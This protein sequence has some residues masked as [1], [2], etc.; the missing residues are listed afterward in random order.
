M[1]TF[2]RITANDYKIRVTDKAAS[3]LI[4]RMLVLNPSKRLGMLSGGE[5]DVT[6]HP[7]CAHVDMAALLKKELKPPWVPKLSDP[8][9][10]SNFDEFPPNTGLGKKYN[11]YLDSKYDETWEKEFGADAA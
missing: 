10:A 11:K 1:R 6:G 5:K 9:D 4:S 8:L 2:A 7:M 3:D